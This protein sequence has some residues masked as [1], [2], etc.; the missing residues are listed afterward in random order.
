MKDFF[1][2]VREICYQANSGKT[3]AKKFLPFKSVIFK[4]LVKNEHLPLT[5]GLAD[6]AIVTLRSSYDGLVSPSKLSGYLARGLPIL[7]IGSDPELKEIIESNDAGAVF[8]PGDYKSL[9]KYLISIR[10]NKSKIL[11][12][13]KNAMNYYENNLSKEKGLRKYAELINNYKDYF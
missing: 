1:H 10:K 13:G 8:S 7:F 4:P 3:F 2:N 5:M 9:S 6:M 11:R 12:Q